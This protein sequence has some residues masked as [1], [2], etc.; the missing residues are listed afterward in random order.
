MPKYTDRTEPVTSLGARP[1]TKK[2]LSQWANCSPRFIEIEVAH[3]RLRAVRL[4]NRFVR[5]LPRDIE[6]WLD[7]KATVAATDKTPELV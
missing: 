6:R 7:S 5:F 2:E 1:V 4:G 3:G